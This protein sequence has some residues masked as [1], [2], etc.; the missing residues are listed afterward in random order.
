MGAIMKFGFFTIPDEVARLIFL[1]LDGQNLARLALVSTE[2]WRISQEKPLWERRVRDY[3]NFFRTS[4]YDPFN[5]F[6]LLDNYPIQTTKSTMNNIHKLRSRDLKA[7]WQIILLSENMAAIRAY[8][9]IPRNLELYLDVT[10]YPRFDFLSPLH[11]AVYFG[12]TE[13]FNYFHALGFPLDVP[14]L[15]YA[16][17]TPFH[18]AALTGNV[19][20]MA[21][22]LS[23]GANPAVA[24]WNKQTVAHYCARSGNVEALRYAL[25]TLHLSATRLTIDGDSLLHLAAMTGKKAPVEYLLHDFPKI[26]IAH[27]NKKGEMA[28][29]CARGEAKTVLEQKMSD[30][31]PKPNGCT[32]S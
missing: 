15:E 20:F 22:L 4:I 7:P 31:G 11:Y 30:P 1:N 8:F 12:N 9:S 25:T 5:E 14:A 24:V 13:M 21:F 16:D 29:N 26:D 3:F 18:C 19:A 10:F 32:I 28:V 17:F 27:R 2:F 6:P 23:K